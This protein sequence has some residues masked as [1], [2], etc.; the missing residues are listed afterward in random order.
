M[1]FKTMTNEELEARR[2][3]IAAELDNDDADLDALEAEVLSINEELE[4]RKAA[5]AKKA[6]IRAKVA[7]GAGE[8][9]K[10]IKEGKEMQPNASE[11]RNSK[12]Y[13]N[14]YAN[15]CEDR[16]RDRMPRPAD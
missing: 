4:A 16:R 5:A 7:A 8:T 12:E 14:A 10:T 9:K 11:I 1:D 2:A 3:A 6:D 15:L 13:I